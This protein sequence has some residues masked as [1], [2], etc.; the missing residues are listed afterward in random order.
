MQNN[1]FA[2]EAKQERS[3]ARVEKILDAVEAL[4]TESPNK[5]ID[6]KSISK[7]AFISVGAIYHHFPSVNSIYASLLLRKVRLRIQGLAALIDSLGPDVTLDQFSDQLINQAFHEWGE[8]P[9]AAKHEALEFY[10]QNAH[11]PE[12]F[13]SYAQS[14]YPHV[15]AFIQRNK[16]NSFRD[17]AEDEWP[18]LN[19]I[20]QTAILSPFLEQSPIAG[21][22]RHRAI[23][24]DIALRIYSK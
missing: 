17:I 24:K 3:Y 10:Y 5:K 16:T 2:H 6:I 19:R 13:Y 14:I 21:T 12:F 22:D 15:L 8:K 11:K 23:V 18:F 9:I 7:K 4:S 1:Y 20:S